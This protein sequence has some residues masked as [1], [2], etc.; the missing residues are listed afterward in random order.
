MDIMAPIQPVPALS[1]AVVL[2]DIHSKLNS[3]PVAAVVRPGT[4]SE[5]CAAVKRAKAAGRPISVAGGRHAMGG[6]QFAAGADH[7]DTTGLN[8]ILSFDA[9]RGMVEAQAGIAWPRLIEG[10]HAIQPGRVQP[11][12]IA[13][14]QTGADRMTLGGSLS[15]N[16]HGRGLTM[17]PMVSD[18]E[19]LVLVD[20]EGEPRE[21][22]R[23][24]EPELFSLVIG[25]YGLF[26]V[27][28]SVCLRLARRTVVQRGVMLADSHDLPRLFRER[29]ATGHRYGDFQFAIDHTRAD[30]LR[31]GILSCYRPVDPATPVP[32]DQRALSADDWLGLLR[33]AH[34]DKHEGFRRYSTHYL[35][36]N[37][38]LY[39]SDTAQLSPYLDD[40]HHALDGG[41]GSEIIGEHYVPLDA[42]PEFMGAAAEVL[43]GHRA[44]VIYGTVRLI[45]RDQE[46]FLPWA[47]AD[48]ACVVLNLHTPH[49]PA[50]I[51]QT[52][53]AFRAVIDAAIDVGGSFYLTYHR[54]ATRRQLLACHPRLPEFLSL[55]RAY[56]ADGRFDSQ[57]HRHHAALL[58]VH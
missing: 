1:A 13:Q 10:L 32:A 38:Q 35:A 46:S 4:P 42:L 27:V 16:I 40:Y 23:T 56:D 33:L 54:F 52:A 49:T 39:H 51:D 14:K 57:W 48:S 17:A 26:G 11:W 9:Q 34:H 41:C 43:R 12:T 5:L 58:G 55:K 24:C 31:T 21:V 30:F 45:R 36:T 19:S 47:R 6:Q 25:G 53:G 28:Y 37:G 3:T 2:N 8:R 18:I 20:S 15:S 22:S 44:D 7:I 29:I 50:G